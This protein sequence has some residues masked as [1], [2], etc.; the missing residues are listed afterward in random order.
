MTF[1][2]K[3]NA[4]I[5]NE[6]E[7]VKYYFTQASSDGVDHRLFFRYIDASRAIFCSAVNIPLYLL[8]PAGRLVVAILTFDFN[9]FISQCGK[10]FSNAGNSLYFTAGTT[11]FLFLTAFSSS[12]S[13]RPTSTSSTSSSTHTTDDESS[14]EQEGLKKVITSGTGSSTLSVDSASAPS[15][16]Q[17]TI[18]PASDGEDDW[19]EVV[20]PRDRSSPDLPIDSKDNSSERADWQNGS[21]YLGRATSDRS[22]PTST[23]TKDLLGS[24][25][26]EVDKTLQAATPE[27]L[28]TLQY[29]S[30]FLHI[31]E[32]LKGDEWQDLYKGVL[33]EEASALKIQCQELY[34]CIHQKSTNAAQHYYDFVMALRT[35]CELLKTNRQIPCINWVEKLCHER[36]AGLELYKY[37]EALVVSA[38]GA[39]Q[40][41]LSVDNF[42]EELEARNAEIKRKMK[43]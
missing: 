20:N 17:T 31:Q 4:S 32:L 21:V 40:N 24:S 25:W 11:L 36:F 13:L 10:D 33:N 12:Y 2:Q 1:I 14:S 5:P 7:S 42:W 28:E 41:S 43:N 9:D 6:S 39:F 29:Q 15:S 22:L 19:I 27:E 18:A 8:T 35:T 26:I 30:F 34:N 16:P 37:C 23:P 3:L 38:S